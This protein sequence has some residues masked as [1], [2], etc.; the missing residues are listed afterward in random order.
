MFELKETDRITELVRS[1]DLNILN[2][3]VSDASATHAFIYKADGSFQLVKDFEFSIEEK[4]SS[5]CCRELLAVHKMLVY[6]SEC[7]SAHKGGTVYW[8]TD[9][10]KIV[11]VFL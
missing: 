2:L 1:T 8:Q 6:E 9:F 3:F 4:S 5:S 10:R 11:T 7:F